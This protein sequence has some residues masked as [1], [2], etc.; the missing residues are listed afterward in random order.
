MVA[1]SVILLN[2]DCGD[3]IWCEKQKCDTDDKMM[4]MMTMMTDLDGLK[5]EVRFLSL[6]IH[7][8]WEKGLT[9]ELVNDIFECSTLDYLS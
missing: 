4:S 8:H 3:V 5:I 2:A 7:Q 6:Q 9:D 1:T